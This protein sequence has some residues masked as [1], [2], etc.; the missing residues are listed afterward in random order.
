MAKR[1]LQQSANDSTRVSKP[2]GCCRPA[3]SL[4]SRSFV[5]WGH[6]GART[7]GGLLLAS[8]GCLCPAVCAVGKA[9]QVVP[10]ALR[11]SCPSVLSCGQHRPVLESPEGALGPALCLVHPAA[12]SCG[13]WEARTSRL[14][15][16]G[17]GDPWTSSKRSLEE[18]LEEADLSIQYSS[19]CTWPS[20]LISPCLL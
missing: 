9:I 15:G 8:V 2:K 1:L 11:A 14:C 20:C 17:F 3:S 4:C 13:L 12:F 5:S 18:Q 16:F 19:I 10:W 7:P 6:R